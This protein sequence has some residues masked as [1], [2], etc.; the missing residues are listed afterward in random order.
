MVQVPAA[1]VQVLLAAGALVLM[2]IGGVDHLFAQGY[3]YKCCIGLSFIFVI[4][5]HVFLKQNKTWPV[6]EMHVCV[7]FVS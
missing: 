6:I 2:D 3:I 5:Y 4:A 1:M 7:C